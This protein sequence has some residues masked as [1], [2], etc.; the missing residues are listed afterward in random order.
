MSNVGG[1]RPGAGRP[2]GSVS[3]RHVEMLAAAVSEG[4]TPVEYMLKV[5][6]DENADAK[7]RAWAA[8]KAAPY[9]HPRPAPLARPI[10]IDLPDTSTIE[11][12]SAALNKITQAVATGTI[13]TAEAQGLVSIVESQRKVIETGEMI[14]RIAA[15]E[16]AVS[17]KKAA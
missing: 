3:K 6:R 5:L 2:K 10:E 4:I 15:L 9:I 14:D 11:G 12:I 16:E 7:A 13:T 17:K 1:A 8:E